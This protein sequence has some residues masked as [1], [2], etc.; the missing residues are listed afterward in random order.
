M[1][2]AYGEIDWWWL[3]VGES[4]LAFNV[5]GSEGRRPS[6]LEDGPNL[7]RQEAYVTVP[8]LQELISTLSAVLK[9]ELGHFFVG[10]E[11]EL[12]GQKSQFDVWFVSETS[13]VSSL[14]GE[15]GDLRFAHSSKSGESLA[16][17]EHV[18]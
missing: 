18:H 1:L 5:D 10:V 13:L 14:R 9:D 16:F 12:F 15:L 8:L 11:A 2:I 4:E 3:G 7:A 6:V 17:N